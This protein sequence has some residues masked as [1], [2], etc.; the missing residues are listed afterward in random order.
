M[1]GGHE[2]AI[3]ADAASDTDIRASDLSVGDARRLRACDSTVT[4]RL[5][6][7]LGR[8]RVFRLGM[9]ATCAHVTRWL[10]TDWVAASAALERP[11]WQSR[12]SPFDDRL[13]PDQP[14][15]ANRGSGR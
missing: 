15:P 3:R 5:G 7:G 13:R 2:N 4:H 8:V 10:L 1:I 6:C 9:H 14:V 11:W 12:R